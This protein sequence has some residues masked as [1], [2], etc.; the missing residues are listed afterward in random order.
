MK[1]RRAQLRDYKWAADSIQESTSE[2]K[3]PSLP[4]AFSFLSFDYTTSRYLNPTI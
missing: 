1:E 3:H 2:V 4:S